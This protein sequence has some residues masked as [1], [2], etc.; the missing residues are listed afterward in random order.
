M[1]ASIWTRLLEW[2]D[3]PLRISFRRINVEDCDDR[4]K[5]LYE[6]VEYR[7]RVKRRMLEGS[8]CRL[9]PLVDRHEFLRKHRKKVV[10][11]MIRKVEAA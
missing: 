8:A 7:A 11:P 5:T 4:R 3:P 10:V 9:K 6:D 1:R 2:W